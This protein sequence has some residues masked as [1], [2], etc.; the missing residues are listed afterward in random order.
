MSSEFP[1][2]ASFASQ[3]Y[4]I[5]TKRMTLEYYSERWFCISLAEQRVEGCD[6]FAADKHDCQP[7][8][9]VVVRKTVSVSTFKYS[10]YRIRS[11]CWPVISEF[12][13]IATRKVI[14]AI[15]LQVDVGP[16]STWSKF[17]FV[18][19]LDEKRLITFGMAWVVVVAKLC[20][21]S[22]ACEA[23]NAVVGK[24]KAV[25]CMRSAKQFQWLSVRTRCRVVDRSRL[26]KICVWEG[27]SATQTLKP[28]GK[29]AGFRLQ[30]LSWMR[31]SSTPSKKENGRD[32]NAT[33]FTLQLTS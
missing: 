11:I 8:C 28:P 15:M 27:I 18:Q 23:P 14:G 3:R 5:S 21:N 33:W 17:F 13:A 32:E 31:H 1:E 19:I 29:R 30:H 26:E 9:A 25:S 16:P 2:E 20:Y 4:P 22:V 24:N 7:R 12:G 6:A 10:P